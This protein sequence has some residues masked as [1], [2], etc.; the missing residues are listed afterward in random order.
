[1]SQIWIVL[2]SCR[3]GTA[4]TYV[5][6]LPCSSTMAPKLSPEKMRATVEQERVRARILELHQLGGMSV[7]AIAAH[8]DVRKGKSTVQMIIQRFDD[9]V[10]LVAKKPA[11]G[12]SY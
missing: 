10:S 6:S 12:L 9:R 2:T 11:G 4:R 3:W 5:F 7:A 8:Q 1:M